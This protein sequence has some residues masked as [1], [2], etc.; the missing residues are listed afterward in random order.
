MSRN[1][2]SPVV[3]SAVACAAETIA[4]VLDEA[5]PVLETRRDVQDL[6]LR[7]RGYLMQ[8]A[9]QGPRTGPWAQALDRARRLAEQ[10]PPADDFLQSRVHLRQLALQL[11]TV[12]AEMDGPRP[13]PGPQGSRQEAAA[14]RPNHPLDSLFGTPAARRRQ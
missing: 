12:L 3:R 9:A 14:S 4:L 10:A 6:L 5:A 2:P 13:V 11:Q 7:L 8:L 1:K